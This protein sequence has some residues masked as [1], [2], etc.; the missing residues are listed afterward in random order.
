MEVLVSL[1]IQTAPFGNE[2][3]N[4]SHSGYTSYHEVAVVGAEPDTVRF[5]G[6]GTLTWYINW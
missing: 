2:I 5:T 4:G 3:V 1:R 6:I